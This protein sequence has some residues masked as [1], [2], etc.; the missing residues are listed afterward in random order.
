MSS[1]VLQTDRMRDHWWWR[2]GWQEGCRQYAWHLTFDGQAALHELVERFQAVLA[3][4]PG[5]DPVPPRWLHLT[6]QG[7]GFTH[8]VPEDQVEAIVQA[9]RRLL[10]R[11]PRLQLAFGPA[12]VRAEAVEL[13][14]EPAK[15]VVLVRATIRAAMAAAWDEDVPERPDGFEPHLAVAYSNGDAPV[16]P[17]LAALGTVKVEP[18][19]VTVGAASLVVLRREGHLYCWRTFATVPFGTRT[20]AG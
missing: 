5:L 17:V 18:I 20:A 9:A 16:E 2:P 10:V 19:T 13:H 12:V 11:L 15:D 4:L 3:S 6:M 7:V 8:Q 14:P 1:P